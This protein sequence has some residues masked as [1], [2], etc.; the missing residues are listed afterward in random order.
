MFFRTR[1]NRRR[2]DVARKASELS[3]SARAHGPTALAVLGMLVGTAVAGLGAREAWG[4]ATTTPRLALQDVVVRGLARATEAELLRLGP[5]VRGANLLSLEPTALERALA[6]HPW[7]AQVT[8]RREFPSRLVVE[9]VEH[10]PRA[11]LA[12][13]ELY[14]LDEAGVPFKRLTVGDASDLPLVTGVDRE[15]LL[16]HREATLAR[17]AAAVQVVAD[18]ARTTSG[19]GDPLSEVHLRP[20]GVTLTTTSGQEVRLGEAPAAET[21]VRLDAVRAELKGRALSAELIRLDN[22]ARPT[23]VTVQVT[24]GSPERGEPRSR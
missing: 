20:E 18:Y 14:L 10:Q 13:G 2:L 15:E 23:W 5:I 24:R 17:L 3:A 9:V 11:L 1:K 4:W 12:L 22:R 7:V 8:V 6:A 21:L 16:A 19:P